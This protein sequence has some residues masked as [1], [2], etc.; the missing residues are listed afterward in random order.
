VRWRSH[1]EEA[2]FGGGLH[3]SC[4]TRPIAYRPLHLLSGAVSSLLLLEAGQP[5]FSTPIPAHAL[6]V[7]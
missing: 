2:C 5:A 3:K 6:L 4:V 7:Q 1:P